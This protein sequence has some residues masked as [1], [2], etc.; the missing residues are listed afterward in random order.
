MFTAETQRARRGTE[1][2]F[3][4]LRPLR[5]SGETIRRLSAAQVRNEPT[6]SY[7]STTRQENLK[8]TIDGADA[9]TNPLGRTAMLR[10]AP[11]RSKAHHEYVT[12]TNPPKSTSRSETP[13]IGS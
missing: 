4:S 9:G 10:G 12:Q 6:E 3:D 11:Q 13:A 1:N 2:F 8:A 7:K 5:L